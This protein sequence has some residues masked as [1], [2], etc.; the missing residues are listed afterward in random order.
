METKRKNDE[1]RR[2]D[3]AVPSDTSEV[4]MT[5]AVI[6]TVCL[7]LAVG[8]H[9]WAYMTGLR[10]IPTWQFWS[11]VFLAIHIGRWLERHK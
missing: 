11:F 10:S 1:A 2:S 3:R 6:A 4:L 7:F 8:G 9:V 5:I